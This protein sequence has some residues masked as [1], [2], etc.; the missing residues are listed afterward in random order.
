ME[1]M[2]S[3]QP[4]KVLGTQERI[5]IAQCLNLAVETLTGNMEE[6]NPANIKEAARKFYKIKSEL[7]QEYRE[8]KLD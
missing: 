3:E 8:G 4:E 7:E 5:A 1:S 6:L 2:T